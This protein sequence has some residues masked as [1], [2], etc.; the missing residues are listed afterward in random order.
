MAISSGEASARNFVPMGTMP[1]GESESARA[2]IVTI[3]E[4]AGRSDDAL[5]PDQHSY[6]PVFDCMAK[7]IVVSC[8]VVSIATGVLSWIIQAKHNS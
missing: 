4:D 5:L 8:A 6:S 1:R 3:P 7:T 2:T